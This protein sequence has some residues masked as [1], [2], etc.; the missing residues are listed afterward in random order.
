MLGQRTSTTGQGGEA[1]AL[2]AAIAERE[3]PSLIAVRTV[4]GYGNIR[5]GLNRGERVRD[6][7]GAATGAEEG[8]I[9]FGIADAHH[10]VRRQT[11]R[12][13]RPLRAPSFVD[14]V[15]QHQHLC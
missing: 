7:D 10:I 9:I 3:Q 11:Q 2:Q 4:I 15:G 8:L 6:S 5:L 12:L 1:W 13:E 14:V